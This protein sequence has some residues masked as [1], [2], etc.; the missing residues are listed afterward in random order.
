[1]AGDMDSSAVHAGHLAVHQ[2]SDFLPTRM[3][4]V[5]GNGPRS[6]GW[7]S[8]NA[9]AILSAWIVTFFDVCSVVTR[10][11]LWCSCG[12]SG[13]SRWKLDIVG[14]GTLG[15]V[16]RGVSLR[17]DEAAENTRSRMNA[18]IIQALNEAKSF[19]AGGGPQSPG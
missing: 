19:R 6:V 3:M 16:V 14:H 9:L 10:S 4:V 8:K 15:F 18:A 13:R 11:A 17:L 5:C 2:L 7:I 1:M 12:R